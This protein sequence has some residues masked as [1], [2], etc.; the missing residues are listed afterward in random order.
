VANFEKHS[1]YLF[2]SYQAVPFEDEVPHSEA[3]GYTLAL[4]LFSSVHIDTE[5][6]KVRVGN[7][8]CRL[9]VK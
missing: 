5:F 7:L 3:D 6:R 8:V 9:N 1:R 4:L 2:V